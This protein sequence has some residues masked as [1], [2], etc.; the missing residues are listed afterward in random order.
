MALAE[1]SGS[2]ITSWSFTVNSLSIKF[3]E[4][5]GQLSRALG[6]K[7][8]ALHPAVS[9]FGRRP[10]VNAD[11][12]GVWNL[13]G[14]ATSNDL[15]SDAFAWVIAARCNP[16]SCP[17]VPAL[18]LDH[19]AFAELLSKRF[20]NF[21]P[22][23]RWLALQNQLVGE[24]GALHE[25]DDLLKLLIDHRA[26][27]DE[28]HRNIAHLFATAC[29]GDDLLWNDLGLPDQASLSS[30]FSLH[31]PALAAKKSGNM[32]LKTFLYRQICEPIW[33]LGKTDRNVQDM[34]VVRSLSAT[35]G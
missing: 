35:L 4:M 3:Q 9:T 8:D 29:M 15:L 34:D 7:P 13:L 6:S 28:Q 18:G 1:Y 5:F 23:Q 27:A 20:P 12:I 31:F 24:H 21:S 25:F 22:P 30:L 10:M 14:T 16:F 26:C 11:H 19:S 17:F 33:Y 32:Q 2:T